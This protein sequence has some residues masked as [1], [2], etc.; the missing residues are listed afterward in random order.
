MRERIVHTEIVPSFLSLSAMRLVDAMQNF[1]Y[2]DSL[3]VVI[4][5][6]GMVQLIV[7]ELLVHRRE[8]LHY[9]PVVPA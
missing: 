1:G 8:G 7:A 6:T 4:M 9:V 3:A 5:N 2:V